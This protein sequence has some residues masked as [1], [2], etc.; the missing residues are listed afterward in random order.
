[1]KTRR[2]NNNVQNKKKFTGAHNACTQISR[3]P[4]ALHMGGF[5]CY[6]ISRVCLG[7][8]ALLNR[9]MDGPLPWLHH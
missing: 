6:E 3:R 1:M 4:P 2:D 7:V 5:N 9:L 8:K